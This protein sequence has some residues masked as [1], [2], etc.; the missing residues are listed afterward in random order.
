MQ[1]SHS[2][3]APSTPVT[4]LT[5]HC[6]T[7]FAYHGEDFGL[8]V[9]GNMSPFGDTQGLPPGPTPM[10]RFSSNFILPQ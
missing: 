10:S 2:D 6:S 9:G 8:G 7:G 1:G 4:E 5:S 3:F